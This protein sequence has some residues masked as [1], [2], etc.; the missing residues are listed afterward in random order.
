M[1]EINGKISGGSSGFGRHFARFLAG[2]GAHVTLSAR[3][4]EALASP[5]A[6]INDSG[7]EHKV[8]CLM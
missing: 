7:G 8:S 3:R 2:E 5:V 4:A 1:F 6:E